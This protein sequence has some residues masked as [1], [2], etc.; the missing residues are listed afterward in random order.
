MNNQ[1]LI[2]KGV[3]FEFAPDV[4]TTIAVG[5]TIVFNKHVQN[6]TKVKNERCCDK[7]REFFVF[8]HLNTDKITLK[9]RGRYSFGVLVETTPAI[10]TV[11]AVTDNEGNVEKIPL[12]TGVSGEVSMFFAE[13]NST[14]RLQNVGTVPIVL[15]PGTDLSVPLV[16]L[17]ITYEGI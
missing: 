4:P 12:Y 10:N 15:T 1:C 5:Q 8:N 14:V 6:N 16:I 9:K 7:E 13:E 11:I 2:G 17:C 3:T